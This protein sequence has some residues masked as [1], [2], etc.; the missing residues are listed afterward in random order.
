MNSKKAPGI[1]RHII[2]LFR[3]T[4]LVAGNEVASR[5]FLFEV[6]LF[7]RIR[8]NVESDFISI[9]LTKWCNSNNIRYEYIM[10]EE[11]AY[12]YL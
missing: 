8:H 6:P 9:P 7:V 1:Y 4:W 10:I 12:V 2:S 3:T 11:Y 5:G